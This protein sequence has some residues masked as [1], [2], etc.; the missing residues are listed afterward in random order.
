MTCYGTTGGQVALCYLESKVSNFYDY[1]L[2]VYG[3]AWDFI[4]NWDDSYED[5]GLPVLQWELGYIP[6]AT[7]VCPEPLLFC[8]DFDYTDE[9]YLV[10]GALGWFVSNSDYK[11]NDTFTPAH[12]KLYWNKT[13]PEYISH[14]IHPFTVAY[15]ISDGKTVVTSRFAPIMSLEYEYKQFKG[16]Y[17]LQAYDENNWLCFHMDFKNDTG[18]SNITFDDTAIYSGTLNTDNSLKIITH[19]TAVNKSYDFNTSFNQN[20]ADVFINSVKVGSLRN[21]TNNCQNIDSVTIFKYSDAS[22]IIDDY[23]LYYGRDPD[24]STLSE[25]IIPSII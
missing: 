11:V 4:T 22:I 2:G 15:P 17:I 21:F 16:D 5:Y 10:N 14:T 8:D 6:I 23:K 3:S 25:D 13:Q 18:T 1:S 9:I 12:N 24:H 7:N 19:F 20:Y